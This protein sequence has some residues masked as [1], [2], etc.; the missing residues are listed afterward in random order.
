MRKLLLVCLTAVF[1]FAFSESRAQERTVTGRVTSKED[2]SGLPGVNVVIKG[3]TNGTVTDANGNYSLSVPGPDA[4]ITF[5]FIGLVT[6]ETSLAGRSSVDVQMEQD[7]TQLTEIVVVGYGTQDKRTLT[8]SIS[9]VK[10]EDIALMPVSSFDQALNGK[11]SGVQVSVG[12]GLVGQA[13]RIRIRGTNSITSGAD[14]LVVIDGVPMV[15]GNISGV[16]ESNALGDINPADIESYQVLKDGA[17]TAIYGSRAANGIILITTKSGKAGKVKINYDFQAGVNSTARRLKAL[18]AD[19]FIAISNEK[20]ATSGLYTPQALPGPDNVNTDWQDVIFRNGAFQNHNLN[21]SGGSD[22]VSYY[23]SGGYMKQDGAVVNNSLDRYTM[24]ANIDYHGV[25]WLSAG[26]KLSVTRQLNNG[27]NTGNSALSGNVTNALA[28]FPNVPVMDANNP[29]GYN[30]SDDNR[31]LGRGNN[32]QEIASG[33][34]NVKY[35]LDHNKQEADNYRVL[36]NGYLQANIMEGLNLRTQLGA[37][38]LENSDFLT[39]DPIHGDGGGATQGILFRQSSRNLRWNW[40]NTLN[41]KRTFAENHSVAVTIGNEYQKNTFNTFYGQGTTF[42]NPLFLKNNLITGTFN[43][44][45]AGGD[46]TESGFSSY[47]GR[48]NY[49]FRSKYILSFSIRNDAMSSLP[50]ANRQGTFFGGS[51]GWDV[52]REDFFSIE[53]ISQLKVRG[54]WAQVGNTAV[55]ANPYPYVGTYGPQLYGSQSGL[56]Y[57]NVGN[58]NL[59]WEDS[60]KLDIGADIGLMNNRISIAFDYYRNNITNMIL[61][62][63]TPPTVGLPGNNINKNIGAMVN[64]GFEITISSDNL[65]GKS[66]SWN[67]SLTLT[68]NTN[69]ITKLVNDKDIVFDYTIDRVGQPISAIYG[70][71]Y[72]GVNPANGNPLY[73]VVRGGQNVIIQGNPDDNSYYLYN[74]AAPSEVSQS[75]AALSASGDKVILGNSAP[76]IYGGLT[77]TLKWKNFDFDLLLTYSAGNKI[78]NVTRQSNMDMVFRNNITEILDRWTPTHTNTDVPRLSYGNGN[79]INQAGSSISRFVE[80]G[81][82]IRLQNISLGYTFPKTMLSSFAKGAISNLRLYAQVR[83]AYVFTK[84]KGADPELNYVTNS[85]VNVNSKAGVDYNTNPLLRTVTFGL[86]IGL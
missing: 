33:Y 13:P 35:V 53:S 26:L 49:D 12:S 11:A 64:K 43:K 29:T 2:G 7:V 37:D 6:Q 25:E 80:N 65:K 52:A 23:F 21:I 72:A 18:N 38:I 50:K 58:S 31:R 27:L 56:A 55:G 81:D 62:A 86:S 57:S 59:R 48:I 28:A 14:P 10:G 74:P 85:T 39:W 67:T 76:K 77:N 22:Q 15:D 46:F 30:L 17:A 84:Y 73:N 71:S 70:Y 1:A 82:F 79:F 19:E 34:T 83:N 47:F 42:S 41:F 24:R 60:D 68:H 44:Q 61:A 63:P 8:S 32:L 78:M 16:A 69:K 20:F 4:V 45:E 54:S 75:T 5:T 9:S 36:T 51:V 66:L 40:Q 3:T